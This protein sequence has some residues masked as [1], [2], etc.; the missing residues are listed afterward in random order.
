[1]KDGCFKGLGEDSTN[2]CPFC[3]GQFLVV[4]EPASGQVGIIHDMPSCK[5]F[6]DS[7]ADTFMRMVLVEYEMSGESKVKQIAKER[8]N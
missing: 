4:R 8:A 2:R 3:S 7:D 1:M 6:D 5:T